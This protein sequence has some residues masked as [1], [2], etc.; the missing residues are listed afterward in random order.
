MVLPDG[1]LEA[2]EDG[3]GVTR[4]ALSDFRTFFY[5]LI[6]QIQSLLPSTQLC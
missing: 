4:D 5:D 1:T 6:H 2:E 3:G